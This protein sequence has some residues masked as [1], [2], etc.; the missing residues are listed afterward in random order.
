MQIIHTAT[1][2]RQILNNQDN[3]AFVPTMGNLHAG[4]IRLVEIAKQ[5]GRAQSELQSQR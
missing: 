1:E 2:L 3:I 4:H 5:I